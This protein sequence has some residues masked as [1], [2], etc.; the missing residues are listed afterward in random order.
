VLTN[1]DELLQP[2][3]YRQNPELNYKKK[4]HHDVA[5]QIEN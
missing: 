3:S 1:H 4:P 5:G 2:T